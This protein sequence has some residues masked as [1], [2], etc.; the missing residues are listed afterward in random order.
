VEHIISLA[1]ASKK[2]Y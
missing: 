1:H 2:G